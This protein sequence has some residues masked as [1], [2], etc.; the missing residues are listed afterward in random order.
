MSRDQWSY[1][2]ARSRS[3]DSSAVEEIP[4]ESQPDTFAV[5]VKYLNSDRS[6]FH[7]PGPSMKLRAFQLTMSVIVVLHHRAVGQRLGDA[8]VELRPEGMDGTLSAIHRNQRLS[9]S[10]ESTFVA[11][12]SDRSLR[13]TRVAGLAEDDSSS[14]ADRRSRRDFSR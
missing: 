5:M 9:T 8:I 4:A 7:E 14:S 6:W 10:P 11:P 1:S 13:Q 3:D 12:A 2:G